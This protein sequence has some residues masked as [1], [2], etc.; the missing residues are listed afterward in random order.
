[1]A[2]V[3]T[4]WIK[5]A[6]AINQGKGV[7]VK[8]VYKKDGS[9]IDIYTDDS[10]DNDFSYL[11]SA[12]DETP[13]PELDIEDTSEDT[14]EQNLDN[15]NTLVETYN[16]VK[17]DGRYYL[18]EDDTAS[19][20]LMKYYSE[21]LGNHTFT[22][23]RML[24]ANNTNNWGYFKG[25]ANT[26]GL[27]Y[28][29]EATKAFT[30]KLNI[31]FKDVK[32]LFDLPYK[33]NSWKDLKVNKQM[34]KEEKGLVRF[35]KQLHGGNSNALVNAIKDMK[36]GRELPKGVSELDIKKLSIIMLSKYKK[37]GKK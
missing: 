28:A 16:E 30:S 7:M 31:P 20:V 17:E 11:S 2:K 22:Y 37:K 36:H 19:G 32:R 21:M 12:E 26:A 15:A 14:V 23:L 8:T 9:T 33:M 25:L 29:K 4:D 3:S 27:K 35:L 13:E 24:K 10:P 1:M 18:D 34:N 6:E 5:T